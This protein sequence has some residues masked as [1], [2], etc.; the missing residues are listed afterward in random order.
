MLRSLQRPSFAQG[1]LVTIYP[2]YTRGKIKTNLQSTRPLI[3]VPGVRA[4]VVFNCEKIKTK[5]T[6]FGVTACTLQV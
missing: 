1:Q 4:C 5:K 3:A 6:F 2:T